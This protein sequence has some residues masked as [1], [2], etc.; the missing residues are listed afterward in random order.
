MW[1]D[2]NTIALLW[3]VEDVQTQAATRGLKLTKKECR[4]VLELCL[5][6]HDACFGLS[7]DILDLHI[8]DLFRN[9]IGKVA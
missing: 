4:Q 3:G 6:Y 7:W 1:T 8:C 5:K 9:R 2:K